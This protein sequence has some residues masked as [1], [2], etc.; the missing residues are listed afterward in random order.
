MV[1]LVPA[2]HWALARAA[3]EQTERE[4][5]AGRLA[6][7]WAI[8]VF[9]WILAMPLPHRRFVGWVALREFLWLALP[10]TEIANRHA[11]CR[12]G[13]RPDLRKNAIARKFFPGEIP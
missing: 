2:V 11:A 3:M 1:P 9:V 8:P 12:T 7:L 13:E 4:Q 6:Q 5:F 10:P